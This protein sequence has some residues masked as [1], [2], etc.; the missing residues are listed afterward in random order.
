MVMIQAGS[1]IYHRPSGTEWFVMGV[2]ET[3]GRLCVAGREP[4]I[5]LINDCDLVEVGKGL[6]AGE[7]RSRAAIFGPEWG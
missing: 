7:R 5:L 6:T 1:T 2:N 4:V 3:I